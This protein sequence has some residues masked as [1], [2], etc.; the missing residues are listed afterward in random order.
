[1]RAI[2]LI[3]ILAVVALILAIGS[4]FLDISQTRP[5]QVPDVDASRNGVSASGGQAPAFD[6]D[7]GSVE[8]N[9]RPGNLAVP[10]PQ[11][12]I[13]PAG[14]DQQPANTATP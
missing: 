11:V 1:M 9:T 13:T 7:T 2:L 8:I 5:A 10:V 12:E 14:N 3:L 4:G 6:V